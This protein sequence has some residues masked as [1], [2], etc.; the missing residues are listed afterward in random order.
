M[1]LPF[2]VMAVGGAGIA[3]GLLLLGP[4][5]V[6]LVGEEITRLNPVRAFCVA[7]AT[8][9]AVIAAAAMGL[10]RAETVPGASLAIPTMGGSVMIN[11]ATVIQADIEAANGVIHVIDGVLLPE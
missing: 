6:L 8:A 1:G 2:W 5:L 4:R 7:L 10:D 3:L 11:D 9:V